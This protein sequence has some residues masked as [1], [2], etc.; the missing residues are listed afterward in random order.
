MDFASLTLE[1][2]KREKT[3]MGLTVYGGNRLEGNDGPC[4]LN[5]H[6]GSHPAKTLKARLNPEDRKLHIEGIA[7]YCHALGWE[8]TTRVMVFHP[9]EI[10]VILNRIMTVE[11][12][13]GLEFFPESLTT[14]K[15]TFVGKW[16]QKLPFNYMDFLEPDEA[17]RSAEE[18]QEMYTRWLSGKP[19]PAPN[20]KPA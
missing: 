2:D 6:T 15:A 18:W 16:L 14:G 3:A 11:G 4:F 12:E 10:A 8:F 7:V 9:S 13:S 19:T 17:I 1:M 5:L 20:K